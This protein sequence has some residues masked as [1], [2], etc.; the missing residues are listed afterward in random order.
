MLPGL[1][2]SFYVAY[3]LLFLPLLEYKHWFVFS[4]LP[5]YTAQGQLYLVNHYKPCFPCQL[6]AHVFQ[7]LSVFGVGNVQ[8][9]STVWF[10]TRVSVLDKW[11]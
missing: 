3:Y 6:N 5:R 1:F 4:S 9:E 10:Q 2:L 11:S 7:V 8:D